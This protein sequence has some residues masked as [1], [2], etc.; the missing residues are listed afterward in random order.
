MSESVKTIRRRYLRRL[1]GYIFANKALV[2]VVVVMGVLG[3]TL[4][5]VYPQADPV[6]D[7][8]R[9]RP[10]GGARRAA[11]RRRAA[12]HRLF[13]LIALSAATAVLFGIAGYG[14]GHFM[15]KLGNRIVVQ[16]RR[17]LFDHLQR[18]SLHFYSKERTGGIVWRLVHEV[19]GVNRLVD[20]GVILLGLD[21]IQLVI[22]FV[23]LCHI[24]VPLTL[25]VL[26]IMPLYVLTFK[27]FNPHI[28]QA[29]ERVGQHLGRIS[30]NV[31]EQIS[32]VA[33]TKS[34]AAEEREAKRFMADNEEHY[35][36]VD[37]PEPGE[38]RRRRHQRN[39]DPPGHDHHHRLTAGTWPSA[40]PS[41]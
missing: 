13:V 20:A 9:D 26:V 22:A 11:D 21:V 32:A 14:R 1:A 39:A 7:R 30:G 19:H 8:R 10:P 36:H 40:A 28:R 29:S 12:R 35:G 24:S 17:D 18:L 34:Y 5:F 4:P 27:F 31:H 16:I 37:P 6:A 38:P 3:A 15:V 25:A 2:A 33:L 23:L 41:P